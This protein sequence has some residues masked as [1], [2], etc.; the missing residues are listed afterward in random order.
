MQSVIVT[1]GLTKVFG[2]NGNAVHALRGIDL[3]VARGEFVALVG[4]SGSG[5]S[6]LL[7][8][9]GLLTPMDQGRMELLGHVV[10]GK[11]PGGFDY[12]LRWAIGYVFQDSKLI[13]EL[14]VLDNVR[15][16]LVH[17]GAPR[18]EQTQMASRVLETV[19]ML[20]RLHSR[21]RQL[22]SGELM[23]VAIARALVTA[24]R[25]VLADEPTGSLDSVNGDRI[26]DLLFGM[27]DSSRGL[28]VVTH[29]RALAD[30]ADRVLELKD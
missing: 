1:R 15:V 29:N 23:R 12:R 30:R 28:G 25:L 8:V 20:H 14:D 4:P 10:D 18:L 11:Q 27:V 17:R 9:L 26:A 19:G 16:P 7:H 22:S 2:A 6:T 3:D 5:K 13:P 21:P 24:P